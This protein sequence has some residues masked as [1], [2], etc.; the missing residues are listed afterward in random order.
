MG[1]KSCSRDTATAATIIHASTIGEGTDRLVRKALIA[2]ISLDHQHVEDLAKSIT[3]TGSIRHRVASHDNMEQL[4]NDQWI[5]LLKLVAELVC[6]DISKAKSFEK[7]S[8][9]LKQCKLSNFRKPS[10]AT[11]QFTSLYTNARNNHGK[12]HMTA[13][14]VTRGQFTLLTTK[15]PAE[16]EIEIQDYLATQ[17]GINIPEM[18]WSDA[19]DADDIIN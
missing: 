8:G 17:K 11:A 13:Y 1:T 4:S 2:G 16:V 15:L 7:A 10:E 5:G 6:F 18:G 14:I 19:T 3:M 12:E 9:K